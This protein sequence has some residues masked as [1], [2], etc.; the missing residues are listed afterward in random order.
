MGIQS[1]S[2][3]AAANTSLFPEGMAPSMVNDSARQVQADIRTWYDDAQWINRGDS[4]IS[5]NANAV[6][7]IT[8][9]VTTH[10]LAN[11]R[12]KLYDATTLYGA[13]ISST[14]SA[15]D[16]TITVVTDSG[17]LTASLTAVALAALTPTS[18]S[19]AGPSLPFTMGF[20]GFSANPTGSTSRYQLIGKLCFI[21]I[22]MVNGTSNSVNFTVT[23]L[24]FAAS[25]NMV[26]MIYPCYVVDNG[27]PLLGIAGLSAGG[28]TLTFGVAASTGTFT[29]SGT[30]YAYI[31]FCYEIA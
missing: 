21:N 1:Y 31:N 19:V 16:T 8:G 2:S 27:L 17:N 26:A 10:Y 11:R 9:D 14:Y 24:P 20:T 12:I 22:Y 4:G 23:G 13:V 28:T 30:K 3:V 29:N 7:K 15:P 25:S 18:P 6:F 5:R